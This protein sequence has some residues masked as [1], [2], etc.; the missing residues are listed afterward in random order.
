MSSKKNERLKKLI[1]ASLDELKAKNTNVLSVAGISSI[2]D[3][4]I[5]ANGT[6]SRHVKALANNVELNAKKNDYLIIGVEGYDIAEW[7]LI[8]F[9]DVVVHVML[10]ETR[11]FYD[12]EGIWTIN[13]N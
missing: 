3:W 6:S 4:M 2:T 12:L 1:L 11:S 5:I 9:G 8:D 7:V 10:P 13:S